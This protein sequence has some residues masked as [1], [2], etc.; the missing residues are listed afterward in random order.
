MYFK[1]NGSEIDFYI[2]ETETNIQV[3]YELDNDNYQRETG[4][5][6]DTNEK[7]IL[8]YFS[9]NITYESK[10]FELLSCMDFFNA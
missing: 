8:I 3:C 7:N 10:D 6:A 1:K 2:P 9:K 5:F 4:V